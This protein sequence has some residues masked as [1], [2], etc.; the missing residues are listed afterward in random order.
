MSA[1]KYEIIQTNYK[2]PDAS[3]DLTLSLLVMENT[4][5]DITEKNIRE[6]SINYPKWLQMKDPHDTPAVLI[7][8]GYSINDHVDKIKELQSSGATVITMNGSAKWCKDHGIIPDWQ[9][10]V[11]AK[12]ESSAF[13]EPECLGFF[14]SQCHP[15][16]LSNSKHPTLVHF[17]SEAIEELFPE[18]RVKA[19]GY[20][21]LGGGSTVGNASLS[22]AFSQGYREFHIFGYD[23]S[24]HEGNSHGYE[25]AMNMFM[26]TTEITWGG[27]TYTASVAMKRQAEKFPFNALALKNAGCK[28]FVYGEG[29]L[30]TIYNTNYHNLEEREKY[31]LMWHLDAYRNYSPGEMQADYFMTMIKPDGRII[32]FGCG[33]GRAGVKF[34]NAGFDVLLVDFTDN[35]RDHEAIAI[36]FLQGDITKGIQVKGKYGYCTDVLEHIPTKD[37]AK[38]IDNI[39]ESIEEAFLQISTVDD[40]MGELIGEPLHLTVKSHSWW[41]ELIEDL[42]YNINWENEQESAALFYI[43]R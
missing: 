26:P 28:L 23:S 10:I 17:G 38:T 40:V 13:V 18:E 32:D 37:V 9:V 4:P 35:C 43:R 39:M 22:V 1:P 19:G 15:K 5:R 3:G 20:T 27:K 25:Q 33:T 31:Q 41:K 42:G 6:N 7:G 36:P 24:Y 8:G 12:E 16:T 14:A 11:D 30:Q 2:N 21:L 34:V 29:L